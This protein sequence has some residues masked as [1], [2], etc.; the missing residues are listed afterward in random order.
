MFCYSRYCLSYKTFVFHF[1]YQ[2]EIKIPHF[3][4]STQDYRISHAEDQDYRVPPPFNFDQLK[5]PPPPPPPNSQN[6]PVRTNFTLK[7]GLS[8]RKSQ[9]NVESID[10]DLSDDDIQQTVSENIKVLVDPTK[11]DKKPSLMPPP[12]PPF[13]DLPDDV[14]ANNLLDD[15]N[16]DLNSG[17]FND[18]VGEENYQGNPP[19]MSNPPPANNKWMEESQ[20]NNWQEGPQDNSW[21]EGSQDNSWQEGPQDNS[22]QEGPQDNSWVDRP[23]QY[24]QQHQQQYQDYGNNFRGR[25]NVKRGGNWV[26]RGGRGRGFA[27]FRGGRGPRGNGWSNRGWGRA[28]FRG[29]HR[30]GY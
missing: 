5:L 30:G 9:D 2:T 7:P 27:P 11:D 19:W 15:L 21:M 6:I 29:N 1:V 10:M 16:N 17:E 18:D 22:W 20:D 13:S 28:G 4:L 26:H 14:D 25:G 3:F 12:P 24:Q 8:P 23:P